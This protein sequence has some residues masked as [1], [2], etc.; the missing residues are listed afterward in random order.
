MRFAKPIPLPLEDLSADREGSTTPRVSIESPTVP[1]HSRIP[2]PATRIS[3]RTAS[4]ITYALEE[5]LRIP[6]LF[7]P[8]LV[9][10]NAPMSD[11][12]G[13]GGAG[14]SGRSNGGS[15]ATSGPRPVP[16]APRTPRDVMR[17]RAARENKKKA[18]AEAAREREREE[19]ENRR[20]REERR[21]S[22]ER[23][24]TSGTAAG[25]PVGS[26]GSGF[27]RSSATGGSRNSGGELG[28]AQD[29]GRRQGDRISSGNAARPVGAQPNA[30][31]T[32][33]DREDE[34][35]PQARGAYQGTSDGP[36][37]TTA[38]P[39][40]SSTAQGQP[41]T[42]SA[43][44][45]GVQPHEPPGVRP[46][47]LQPQARQP[48]GMGPSTQAQDGP[49]AAATGT[50]SQS[51]QPPPSTANPPPRKPPTSSFP[52]A[53]ERWETLSS[54]W[55]GLTSYWI[56]RLEQNSEE[57]SREPLSQQMARQITDLSAAGANLFHAVVELQRLRA[58]SERKFQRWFFETRAE[59]ER[60]QEMQGQ[61]ENALRLE[62]QQRAQAVAGA[63]EIQQ[64]KANA[65]RIVSEKNRE[66]QIAKEEAR[67]A[68]D[69]LGRRE[70]EER[71][72]TTSLKDGQPTLVGGVQ[73][74]PMM[75]GVPSRQTSSAMPPTRGGPYP[76]GPNESAMGG[77]ARQGGAESPIEGQQGYASYGPEDQSPTDT[78]P[79]TEVRRDVQP[80]LPKDTEAPASSASA[81]AQ[82]PPRSSSGNGASRAV[83][84][85]ISQPA[86]S[87]PSQPPAQAPTY[88]HYSAAS[89]MPTTS[90]PFYQ[91]QGS[92]LQGAEQFGLAQS[93]QRSQAH[94]AD[95]TFSDEEEYQLDAQG[96][97]LTDANNNPLILRGQ[98]S[99]RSESSD[100]YDVRDDQMRERDL[101]A[102]YGTA[103][104]PSIASSQV[105]T[106]QSYG[107]AG[108]QQGGPDYSG[109]GYA[110]PGWES[111]VTAPRPAHHHPT[112]LSDVP[113]EDERSRTSASRASQR[114]RGF[115]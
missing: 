77:Q 90:A 17:D 11:L 80:P 25:G 54:H 97:V 110:A 111:S 99:V 94:S 75:Q 40:G 5:G 14:G 12:I 8:D 114:S 58:S 30:F 50:A 60:A 21:I 73:V 101:Q 105:G 76:G 95:D 22:A 102:R 65:E 68:W 38:R 83:Y 29:T 66:L 7:T 112:R 35:V 86:S 72:R 91:H 62:R 33:A 113:E 109:A 42:V 82:Y 39:R 45:P 10:E 34:Q 37:A 79:F 107:S 51:A 53:F 59:Q 41:R 100:E 78:D 18:E 88:L 47:P 43:S 19:E 89:P 71:D 4:A 32:T 3:R 67:R 104:Q 24:A 2:H 61:L 115:H 93:D 84:P 106:Q 55:E 108:G 74:V 46:E 70:Q 56:R 92:S 96:N 13:G 63:T 81:R 31:T 20:A 52:H 48:S 9:E 26:G 103:G 69:E 27:R 6:N 64:I 49:S 87:A 98:R 1:L 23:R 36:A 44:L 85:T 57:V 16:Q 15:R 28:A